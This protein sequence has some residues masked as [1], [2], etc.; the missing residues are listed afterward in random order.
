MVRCQRK[1][2]KRLVAPSHW[3]L[4]KSAGKFAVHPSAG[5]HKLRECLPL[6]IFLRDRLKYALNSREAENIVQRRLVKIDGKVRTNSR[7]PTGLMDVVELGKSNEQFRVIYDVKGRFKI[8]KIDAKEA[9]FKLCRITKYVIG[10][11]GIP[12]LTTHDGRTIRFAN[13]EV[14]LHDSVKFNLKT[15]DVETFYKFKVGNFAMVTGGGNVGRCGVIRKIEHQMANFN[16]VYLEDAE[17][18]TFATRI[19]NVF[20][21]GEGE[22]PSITLPAR[23]GVRPSILEGV[24]L[25]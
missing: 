10:D 4:A 22:H 13:P 18:N 16:I 7:Y 1:H 11:K 9:A 12:H 17:K 19:N 5:P 20:V 2:L 3:M 25:D 15:H 8:H 24:S 14:R 21:I 23:N 6:V